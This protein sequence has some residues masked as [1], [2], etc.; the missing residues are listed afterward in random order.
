MTWKP[1]EYPDVSPYLVVSDARS[2]MRF[3]EQVFDASELRRYDAD[4][5]R[6]IHI[7]LRIGDSVVM[8]GEAAGEWEPVPALLHVYVPDVD[9]VYRRALELGAEPVQEPQVR[10]GDPDRR[11]GFRGPGG[12]TWWVA[13]QQD[14]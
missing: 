3:L 9:D 13:T 7:E 1:E 14:T 8:M 12:N 5:G 4:D 11:G 2:T 10:E 6:I